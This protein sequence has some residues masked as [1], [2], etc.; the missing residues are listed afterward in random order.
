V[1][2]PRVS[3]SGIPLDASAETHERVLAWFAGWPRGRVL[4]APAGRGAL[5]HELAALGFDVVAGDSSAHAGEGAGFRRV[6]LD[7][8]RPLP[9]GDAAFDYVA[10]IEG[11]EHLERPVDALREMRRVLAAGGTLV[12]TTPNVLHLG[13]RARML[14]TGFWTSAPRP[15]DSSSAATG[16]EHIMLL[17]YPMLRYFLERSGFAIEEVAHSRLVRGSVPWAWL[18]LPVWAVTRLALRRDGDAAIAR[19]LTR[20]ALM[21]GHGLVFRCRAT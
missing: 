9:F 2:R 1:G 11:I 15:F 5:S 16:F 4:D 14:F 10:C 6:Q 12:L 8:N 17:S 13:S 7:L 21:F 3:R 20:P 19:D 18:A